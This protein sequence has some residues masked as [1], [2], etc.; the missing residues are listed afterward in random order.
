MLRETITKS[1]ISGNYRYPISAHLF[2]DV[3]RRVMILANVTR[4]STGNAASPKVNNMLLMHANCR[5]DV[6]GWRHVI[7]FLDDAIPK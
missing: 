4:Q 5:P 7:M 1:V 2:Y 6:Y 3:F